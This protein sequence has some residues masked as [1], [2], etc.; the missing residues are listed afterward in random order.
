MIRIHAIQTGT[1]AIKVSQTIGRGQGVRRQLNILTD[2]QWTPPLPIYAWVIEHPEGV[3]VVDT[4]ETARTATPGYFPRWNPYFRRAVRATVGPEEEIGPQ[5]QRLGI[6]PRD[7]RWV[8]LTHFHTDH[9]GGLAHFPHAEIL[10]TRE[11]YRAARTL[12]G[13]LNGFLPQYWPAWFAPR[14]VELVPQPVGP[15]ATS[16]PLTRAGDVHIVPT[17][18]HTPHHLSVVFHDGATTCFFAG[19]TSYTEQLMVEQ[20]VDGVSPNVAVAGQTLARI[21]AFAAQTPLVYLPSHDP[22]AAARLAARTPVAL[23]RHPDPRPGP[24]PHPAALPA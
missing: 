22:Q 1:V 8:I 21:R 18:G 20:R 13:R 2:P 10:T 6:G 3:I 23:A 24:L 19:D 7:V 11:E 9:A 15:F 4:G 14:F 12:A 16:Q 5:L 17:P